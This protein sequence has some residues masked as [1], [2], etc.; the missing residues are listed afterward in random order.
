MGRK[1]AFSSPSFLL[2]RQSLG[3]IYPLTGIVLSDQKRMAEFPKIPKHARAR[4]LSPLP[5]LNHPLSLPFFPVPLCLSLS[6]LPLL[7]GIKFYAAPVLL[8]I[9]RDCLFSDCFQRLSKFDLQLASDIVQKDVRETLARARA[10]ISA[11]L[12]ITTS[13]LTRMSLTV[14][15]ESSCKESRFYT[16]VERQNRTSFFLKNIVMRP[17]KHV[18]LIT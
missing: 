4:M 8:A 10:S 13:A 3:N 11:N 6:P 14:E 18:T 16:P 2:L 15:R 17:M 5:R 1:A 7:R 12:R 9:K